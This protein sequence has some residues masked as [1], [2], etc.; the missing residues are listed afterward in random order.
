MTSR[1][2]CGWFGFIGVIMFFH[3]VMNFILWTETVYGFD[4]LAVYEAKK[5]DEIVGIH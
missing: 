1:V 5:M 4:G 3:K 2:G